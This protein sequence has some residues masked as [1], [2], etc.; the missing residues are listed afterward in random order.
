MSTRSHAWSF[1]AILT[2]LTPAFA[3]EPAEQKAPAPSPAPSSAPIPLA[4]VA[5]RA[6]EESNLL[7]TFTAQLAPSVAIESILVRLP[8]ISERINADMSTLGEILRAERP[9]G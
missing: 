9:W 2:L 6:A 8:E 7:P 5:T 4:E 3:G 1:L